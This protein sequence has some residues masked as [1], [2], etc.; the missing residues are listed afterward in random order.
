MFAGVNYKYSFRYCH[1][2][3][4]ISENFRKIHRKTTAME[5]CNFSRKGTQLQVFSC[6]FCDVFQSKMFYKMTW[7][8]PS[9]GYLPMLFWWGILCQQIMRVSV[10]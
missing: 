2:M 1:P 3:E 10:S 5:F 7:E 6:E 9:N 8:T 4:K